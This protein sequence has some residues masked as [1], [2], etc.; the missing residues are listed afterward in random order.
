MFDFLIGAASKYGLVIVSLDRK[1]LMG[2][3]EGVPE[4]SFTKPSKGV[5]MTLKGSVP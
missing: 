2:I 5:N 3:A 1:L 4:R